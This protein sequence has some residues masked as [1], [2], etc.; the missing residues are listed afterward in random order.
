MIG[1]ANWI[2]SHIKEYNNPG[3]PELSEKRMSG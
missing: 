1:L 3:R 2:D